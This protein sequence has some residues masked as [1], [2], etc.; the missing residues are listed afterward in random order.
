MSSLGVPTSATPSTPPPSFPDAY[1]RRGRA[2]AGTLP[3][4]WNASLFPVN[5]RLST[6]LTPTDNALYPYDAEEA[7]A[8]SLAKTLDYLGLGEHDEPQRRERASTDTGLAPIG[9]LPRTRQRAVSPGPTAVQDSVD[10]PPGIV[11]DTVGASPGAAPSYL[12]GYV[13]LRADTIATLAEG[14]LSRDTAA[15]HADSR[16][17]RSQSAQ[18]GPAAP[19]P[20][21][22]ERNVYVARLSGQVSTRIL[23][24]LFEPYGAI[25]DIQL[26]PHEGAALIQYD[27]VGAAAAAADAG[28]AYIGPYLVELLAEQTVLPLFSLGAPAEESATATT[29]P[30]ASLNTRALLVS[31]LPPG[32]SPAVLAQL[33]GVHG[34]LESVVI[35]G[36]L[37]QVVFERVDDAAAALLALDASLALGGPLPLRVQ[38]AESSSPSVAFG[39]IP[40]VVPAASAPA[41]SPGLMLAPPSHAM[42]AAPTS[43]AMP[44]EPPVLHSN[45][46]PQ[47]MP[48]HGGTASIVPSSDKGGVPLPP[49]H[50][51]ILTPDTERVLLGA[52][53]FRDGADP[54]VPHLVAP[55]ARTY[56]TQIPVADP[57]AARRFDHGR[58]RELRKTMENG[59]LSRAQVDT[60]ALEQLD[61]IVELS[62]N[63]IGNTVVQRYFEQASESVK[64]RMLERLAPHLASIGTHK[65]GTWAAQKIIDCV[66]TDEQRALIATH[67]QPYV[68]ALLLDQFGNYVVQCVLPFGFPR[69]EFIVDAMVDR[70]WE[71]AQ[72]RFGARSMRTCLESSAMPRVHVKR[73]ALAIALHCV[74][75]ATSA[76]GALLLTWL[77]DM[78]GLQGVPGLLAPRFVPHLARLCT[79][80]L[81]S[82]FVLRL[83]SQ[84]ENADAAGLILNAVF[85]L[86][87][88]ASVLEE[89]LVDP[90]HGAQFVSRALLSPAL[91]ADARTRN[92]NAV[93]ILLA[94]YELSHVPAYRRLAEQ[95]GIAPLD[96]PPVVPSMKHDTPVSFAPESYEAWPASELRPI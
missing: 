94:K 91:E 43:L 46:T 40:T 92:V 8:S 26:F 77:F 84:T 95:V 62:R 3:S 22:T 25:E 9:A 2:R 70:C 35:H 13:R 61:V 23:L 87:N 76:N 5:E 53:H 4:R 29:P 96:P 19:R 74:P 75:L 57:R 16:R 27:D 38:P 42:D 83:V 1:M 72:G 64:T 67:L 28:A 82:G 60:S 6:L 45:T 7:Q 93:A 78:S 30:R 56:Y 18:Q 65:N 71:I 21:G 14:R 66:R 12:P 80:K 85:D 68:P 51:P 31:A 33:F 15:L 48:R 11:F 79:H 73:I 44:V 63:Y 32:T 17:L 81:A 24:R 59:Q 20:M 90:V 47:R 10:Q 49:D 39:T 41:P 54:A 69:C 86:H 52:L 34:A 89:I 37:A 50:V 58:L 55:G 88:D 36:G